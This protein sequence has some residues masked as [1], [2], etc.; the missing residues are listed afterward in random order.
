MLVFP[1]TKFARTNG[2]RRQYFHLLSEVFELGWSLLW[3]DYG[4]AGLEAVDAQHS[5][6]TLRWIL[7]DRHHVDRDKCAAQVICGNAKRG[8]YEPC[9]A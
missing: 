1:R 3:R 2:I 5:A 8:Y 4:H 9:R 6:D 7:H